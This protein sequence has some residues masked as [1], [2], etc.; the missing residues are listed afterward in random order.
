MIEI[1]ANPDFTRNRLDYLYDAMI[2]RKYTDVFFSV[3]TRSFFAH[4]VVLSA[5]SDY[6]TKNEYKLSATFSDFEYPVI[7]AMLKYCYTGKIKIDEKH[8]E[9][10]RKLADKLEIKNISPRYKTIDKK[11]CLEVLT[12]SD[13][14]T[15]KEKAMELTISNFKTWHKT[16]DFLSLPVSVL[17]EILKSE[18]TNTESEE[19]IF[20]SVKLW[21]NSDKANRRSGL[22]ELFSS[23]KLSLLSTKFLVSEVADFVSSYPE[24]NT[25][26][27]QAL[28]SNM[29]LNQ[30][31][32]LPRQRKVKIALIGGEDTD[33]GNTIDIYDGNKWTLSRDF[34]F[35]RESYASAIIDD[36]IMIIGGW[37]SGAVSSVDYVDLKDGQKQ[38][39]KPLNES[40]YNLS[41]VTLCFDSSTDVYAIGGYGLKG[42][43]SSVER[44]TMKTK[45]WDANVAPLLQAVYF[46]QASV[47]GDRIYVTGGKAMKN[48]KYIT[49]NEVQM[50]SVESNSWAYRAPMIHGRQSHSSVT[51]KGRLYVGGG[52][53]LQTKT[54]L[55]SVEVFD[56]VANM[57]QSY[58]KLP[59]PVRYHSFSYFRNKLLFMG[60]YDGEI[61][62]DNV[63]EYDDKNDSW[64]ALPNPNKKRSEAIAILIPYDS[65]V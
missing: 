26:F 9:N 16:S 11:N 63:W 42:P 32:S 3:R 20:E 19:D 52:H 53:D 33:T 51:F 39:L 29:C 28:Q 40:R 21:V 31:E 64:K 8:F 65:V 6:F 62:L 22:A 27:K 24:C 38:S 34:N 13:D 48:G 10:F 17:S 59:M 2:D 36:W 56:P 30:K 58:C 7:E 49:T 54:V 41:A 35:D 50:Y 14:P 46:H 12:L 25:I 1:K 55:N 23:V 57:W 60:G 15:S 61:K 45:N 5:C 37:K 43:L 18:D 44:W 47:I 4:M